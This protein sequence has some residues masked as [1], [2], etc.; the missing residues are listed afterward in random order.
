[1]ARVKEIRQK[2]I[3]IDIAVGLLSMV[4]LS[5]YLWGFEYANKD[6]L[7]SLALLYVWSVG[8]CHVLL[9]SKLKDR[10]L[11]WSALL[12]ASG[13]YASILIFTMFALPAMWWVAATPIGTYFIT[14]LRT[15]LHVNTDTLLRLGQS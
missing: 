7:G 12:F 6:A 11:R 2:V 13:S 9:L 15:R 14:K 10:G 5:S 4:P 3:R 1:M 8:A